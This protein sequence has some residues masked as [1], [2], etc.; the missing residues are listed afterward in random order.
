MN[1]SD[2]IRLQHILDAID[3]IESFTKG[4]SLTQFK[5][6]RLIHNATVRCFE[7]IGEAVA[8][9]SDEIRNT[10]TNF[11]WQDWKDFRNVLIHQYF[12]ID[13]EL[14]YNTILQ[15]LPDLK[16]EVSRLIG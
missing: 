16:K 9:L 1:E 5:E 2:E 6:H 8:A 13:Y 3:D 4:I 15:D 7:I 11:P 10:D 12:G 14:V